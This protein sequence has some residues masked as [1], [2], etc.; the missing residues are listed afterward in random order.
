M[1]DF[2]THRSAHAQ[3]T[4]PHAPAGLLPGAPRW[5]ALDAGDADCSFG[6]ECALPYLTHKAIEPSPSSALAHGAPPVRP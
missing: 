2:D 1:G 4:A 3:P 5:Q 6:H